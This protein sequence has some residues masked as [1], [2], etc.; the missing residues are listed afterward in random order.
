M[1][2]FADLEVDSVSFSGDSIIPVFNKFLSTRK[3]PVGCERRPDWRSSAQK[4]LMPQ[5]S[6]KVPVF[7]R[8]G[9]KF[10]VAVDASF[11]EALPQIRPVDGIAN[12]E[13]N[14]LVYPFER[15]GTSYPIGTPSVYFSTWEDVLT[16]LREGTPP[17]P[18]EIL[19]ELEERLRIGS[20]RV[21]KT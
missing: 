7:R 4:R 12:S 14:W 15:R 11:F 8:W 6:L 9:K 5:L 13:I 10:F 20:L 1:S 17:N 21:H 19:T 3:M 18:E 16:A 2:R